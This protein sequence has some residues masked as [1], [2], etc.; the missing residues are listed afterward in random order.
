[1]SLIVDLVSWICLL[2][3]CAVSVIGALGLLRLPEQGR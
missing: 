2:A 1:M 3:G